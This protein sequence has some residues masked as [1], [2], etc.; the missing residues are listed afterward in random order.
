M[1]Q[2]PEM[3]KGEENHDIT[4]RKTDFTKMGGNRC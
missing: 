2:E 3:K 1:K 4:D